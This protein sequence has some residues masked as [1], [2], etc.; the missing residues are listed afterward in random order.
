M[1][2]GY[3][4]ARFS[5]TRQEAGSYIYDNGR[6]I[7][8][9]PH[10][11]RGIGY[12]QRFKMPYIGLAGDYRIGDFECNVLFKYSDWVNAHDN[13]EHHAK[14]TFIEKRKFTILWRFY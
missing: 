10:G 8:N 4:E 14:L 5:W 1:T 6:Y 11:V 7:G 13:D 2:A 9:F 3:Q 12:S